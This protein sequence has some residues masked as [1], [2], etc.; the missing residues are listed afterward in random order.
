VI[1]F[2]SHFILTCLGL[3]T[4]ESEQPISQLLPIGFTRVRPLVAALRPIYLLYSK[5]KRKYVQA[6][7]P[8]FS[9]PVLGQYAVA[10]DFDNDMDI[11]LFVT[12]SLRNAS[13]PNL[14]YRNRGNGTFTLESNTF[15]AAGE[16]LGPHQLDFSWGKKAIT[17]D[18]DNNG[19]LD[20][21]TSQTRLKTKSKYYTGASAQL[22]RNL[23]NGNHW[24][25]IDLRGTRSNRDGIGARILA[26]AGGVTQLR[27]QSGGMHQYS[28]NASR[29]HFGMGQTRRVDTVEI[30][31]PSGQNQVI[32]DVPVDQ[33][34]TITEP[35]R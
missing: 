31:W 30:R 18:Y 32:N 11:D 24:L 3:P 6:N 27:E 5:R 8:A 10:G 19:F 7:I 9:K 23:G 33:I 20:I 34:M 29:I 15:G 16:S 35:A 13:A 25:E 14:L 12:C 26:T 21:Y 17:A 28:Q 1:N 4:I 2:S 22:F